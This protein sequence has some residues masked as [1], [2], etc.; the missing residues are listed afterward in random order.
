VNKKKFGALLVGISLMIAGCG[1]GGASDTIKIGANLEMTGGSASFGASATNAAKLAINEYNTKGGFK[2][3]KV[4]LV[5]ADNKSEAAESASAMQ[6]L[7]Q[8]K[9]VAVIAP[10]AS[11][12]VIAGA[13]INQDSKVLAISPTASN[14]KVT[15]DEKGKVRP[16]LFRASFIDPFQGSVM[17]AFA[18]KSLKAKTAAIYIDNSSDYAKGLAKYFE[19]EF[20]KAG[21]QIVIKEA[22]LQKDTD[23]KATL[24]KIKAT[25]PEVI[26]VPGYY[27]EVGLIIKQ[28]RDLGMKMPVLGG[29]GWDS[30]QLT[31]IAGAENLENTFF[32]NHYSA[33]DKSPKVTSFVEAYQKAYGQVPDSFAA[34]AYDATWMIIKAM[35]RADSTDPVKIRDEMEKTKDHDGVS[36]K[37]TLNA[38]HDAVKGAVII[39]YQGGKQ[40]FKERVA[41]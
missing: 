37:T 34:L 33:E 24:T 28:S 17:A 1:G 19:E 18:T 11:S 20:V 26:F 14:P 16:Y 36:G 39:A 29:D 27:Q 6:K 3:K 10:I 21:G 35:E 5:I 22:Y 23:F 4:E 25:N 40:V 15:V 31:N 2:G 12:S 30:V 38:T 8:D 13:Q 7:V 41:P 9:V 32:C